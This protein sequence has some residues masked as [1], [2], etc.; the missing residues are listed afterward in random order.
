MKEIYRVTGWSGRLLAEALMLKRREELARKFISS[1]WGVELK[2]FDA[3]HTSDRL[4]D[5]RGEER[6]RD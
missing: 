2:G 6:W 5:S 4:A 3:A 1:E